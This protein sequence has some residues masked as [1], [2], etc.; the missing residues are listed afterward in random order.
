[1]LILT[2]LDKSLEAILLDPKRPMGSRAADHRCSG[3][4]SRSRSDSAA[5][6][7]RSWLSATRFADPGRLASDS[8]ARHSVLGRIGRGVNP[9]RSS[10]RR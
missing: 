10:G 7:S 6:L 2:G 4:M 5:M 1:M 8:P 3:G 9:P